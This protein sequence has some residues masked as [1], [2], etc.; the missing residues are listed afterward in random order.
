MARKIQEKQ[1]FTNEINVFG[2]AKLQAGINVAV[3]FTQI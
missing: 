3:F 2:V 1:R